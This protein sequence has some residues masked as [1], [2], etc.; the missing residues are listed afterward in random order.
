MALLERFYDP[1]SGRVEIN[2][3]DYREYGVGGEPIAI[4]SFFGSYLLLL[5]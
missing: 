5:L 1:V 3:I 2:G 4:R